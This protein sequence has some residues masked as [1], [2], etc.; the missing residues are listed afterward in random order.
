MFIS[1]LTSQHPVFSPPQKAHSFVVKGMGALASDTNRYL[2]RINEDKTKVIVQSPMRPDWS[3]LD[4]YIKS[5]VTEAKFDGLEPGDALAFEL[6]ANPTTKGRNGREFA[7]KDRASI[8]DWIRR[9]GLACGF[10]VKELDFSFSSPTV[11]TKGKTNY[12]IRP[13]RFC[14][15]LEVVDPV[16]FVKGIA[17]GF[18]RAKC[19]GFGMMEIRWP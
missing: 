1:R 2:F 7:L 9:A 5:E 4:A 16:K 19:Y 6:V 15:L 14:G 17:T 3:F 13:V 18:G 10:S 12:V 8:E 11:I